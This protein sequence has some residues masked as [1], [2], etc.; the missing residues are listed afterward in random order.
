MQP[1]PPTHTY[2]PKETVNGWR[3]SPS[4][5]FYNNPWGRFLCKLSN[6]IKIL[7]IPKI[8]LNKE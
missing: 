5:I 6:T 4:V 8:L 7:K 3:A 1:Y 2:T